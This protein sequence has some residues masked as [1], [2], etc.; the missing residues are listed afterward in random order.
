[1]AISHIHVSVNNSWKI[2]L[3]SGKQMAAVQR[4]GSVKQY[5]PDLKV[6][7]NFPKY[8]FHPEYGNFM[9]Y[10]YIQAVLLS[11]GLYM[12]VK[13][14]TYFNIVKK[15]TFYFNLLPMI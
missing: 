1:M 12:I 13:N 4:D 15:K 5:K 2:V 3:L 14:T 11:Y 7:T 10:M 6:I 8:V 9:Y